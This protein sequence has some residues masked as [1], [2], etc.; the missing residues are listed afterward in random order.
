MMMTS[1]TSRSTWTPRLYVR[2]LRSL[3]RASRRRR[4]NLSCKPNRTRRRS[5]PRRGAGA[6]LKEG[7]S[8]PT[9]SSRKL[10][11]T[12]RRVK[13]RSY[14]SL[15]RTRR[16][17]RPATASAGPG[18][19]TPRRSARG[20]RRRPSPTTFSDSRPWPS[21][22]R[23]TTRPGRRRTPRRRAGRRSTSS[24]RGCWRRTS[25]PWRLL[26]RCGRPMIVTRSAS[27]WIRR[28]TWRRSSTA[29]GRGPRTR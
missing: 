20:A 19:T 14:R 29:T 24:G 5:S 2:P 1:S 25:R 8:R 15:E 16:S 12:S 10:G 22:W 4:R 26:W 9:R 17:S 28:S 18:P 27:S 3:P 6:A 11:C 21:S 13:R 23:R 7:R